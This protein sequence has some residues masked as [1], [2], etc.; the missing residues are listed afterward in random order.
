MPNRHVNNTVFVVLN[1]Y[2]IIC[3]SQHPRKLSVNSVL[4]AACDQIDDY[5][6]GLGYVTDALWRVDGSRLADE[7]E[8]TSLQLAFKQLQPAAEPPGQFRVVTL[9]FR[10]RDEGFDLRTKYRLRYLWQVR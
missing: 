1:R 4:R 7:C 2:Y 6:P 8:R 3:N 10:P 9:K 5:Q